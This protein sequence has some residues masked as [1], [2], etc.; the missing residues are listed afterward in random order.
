[1]TLRSGAGTMS[2]TWWRRCV[3]TGSPASPAP[4]PRHSAGGHSSRSSGSS[5]SRIVVPGSP[6][7]SPGRRFPRSRRDLSRGSFFLYA[8][9]D[10]DG[11]DDVDESLAA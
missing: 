10:D 6:G 5:T 4:Q 2:V 9:S 1:M 3:L 7:C 11:R 8:L